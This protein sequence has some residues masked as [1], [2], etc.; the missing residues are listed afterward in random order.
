MITHCEPVEVSQVSWR[1]IN[2]PAVEALIGT[3]AKVNC[4]SWKAQNHSA[5]SGES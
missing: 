1:G 2:Q 3:Q 5:R 4:S